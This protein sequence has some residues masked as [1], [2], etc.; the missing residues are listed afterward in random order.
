MRILGIL[1]LIALVIWYVYEM[2]RIKKEKYKENK[3]G[4][5]KHVL[6]SVFIDWIEFLCIPILLLILWIVFVLLE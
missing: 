4:F 2:K 6:A 3:K 1:M 5:T